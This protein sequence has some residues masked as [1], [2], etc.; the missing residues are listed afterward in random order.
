VP[1]HRAEPGTAHGIVLGD[2]ALGDLHPDAT[3]A[4][5]MADR[6]LEQ[7]RRKSGS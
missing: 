1:A 2:L 6:A 5:A 3:G 7:Y 4:H